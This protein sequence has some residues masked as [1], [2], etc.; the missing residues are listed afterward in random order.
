M[1]QILIENVVNWQEINCKSVENYNVVFFCS[2]PNLILKLI[3]Y[4]KLQLFY[5][6]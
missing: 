1:N 6:F 3:I 4:Q 5:D 2:N